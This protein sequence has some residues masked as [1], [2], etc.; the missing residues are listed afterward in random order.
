[1]PNKRIKILFIITYLELGGAQK[2]LLSILKT[3]SPHKYS[4]T[5]CAGG[6]GYLK[7]KFLNLP[8]V[9]IKLFP[10]LVRE[11][12]PFLD[13]AAFLKL[14]FFIK[15]NKFDIIHTHSPKAS[16]LGRWAAYLAG[17][18]NIIYTV[19][20]WPFHK[21]LKPLTYYLYL[22]L[23]RVTAKITKKII[24]VSY[25]DLAQALRKKI[26]HRDKVSL[27]HYGVEI[28]KFDKVYKEREG[29]I[30][31][32][33]ITISCLKPQKGIFYFLQTAKALLKD[34]LQ[35]NFIIAGDGYLRK[36]IEKEIKLMKLEDNVRLA[37]W[38]DDIIPLFKQASIFVLTSLWEGLPLSLI[39]AVISGVPVVVTNTQGLLDIVDYGKQ[40]IVV[41]AGNPIETE[42]ACREIL[43]DYQ[44]WS[45]IIR[46]N[47]DRLDLSYWSDK[48]MVKEV[49]N[50]M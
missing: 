37:G 28:E 50:I 11:V 7:S 49:E 35:L 34:N 41:N 47:R 1:M 14:F 10:S 29:K 38:V 22:F 46:A 3:L 45:R 40:G 12:N 23:E 26:C 9:R 17:V 16:I 44:R 4:L 33:I 30:P 15:K 42:R 18:R 32:T 31:S 24:V 20:G 48:R 43:K 36:Q 8:W 25:A 6:K 13:L 39:E 5:L 19:H 27:I 21:F 2:Q